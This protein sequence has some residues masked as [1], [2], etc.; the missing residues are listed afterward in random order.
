MIMAP[1]RHG[2]LGEVPD[3]GSHGMQPFTAQDEVV[4]DQQKDVEVGRGLF[5][6]DGHGHA[7][8]DAGGGHAIAAR[9]A[10]RQTRSWSR[11]EADAMGRG[12]G[13]EGVRRA[14][15]DQR[16]HGSTTDR[17]SEL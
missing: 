3:D 9:D 5:I 4:A 12:V 13:D 11:E 2:E 7:V 1:E 15:V 6:F 10:H 17:G 16:D 8:T 14:G